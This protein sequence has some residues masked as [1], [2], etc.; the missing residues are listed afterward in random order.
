MMYYLDTNIIIYSVKGT[1]TAIKDHF[2]KIPMQSIV[3]P[4]SI[5]FV[6]P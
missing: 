2:R 4:D 5:L 1:F 6:H 3:I